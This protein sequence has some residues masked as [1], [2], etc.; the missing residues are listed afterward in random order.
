M[1]VQAATTALS[2]LTGGIRL[3]VKLGARHADAVGQGVFGSG[4]CRLA[5]RA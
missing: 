4:Q 1:N 3:R 2:V 5:R